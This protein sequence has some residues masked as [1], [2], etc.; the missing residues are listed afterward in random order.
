MERRYQGTAR[1]IWS[2][3]DTTFHLEPILTSTPASTSETRPSSLTPT[4]IFLSDGFVTEGVRRFIPTSSLLL[5]TEP[6]CA[7]AEGEGSRLEENVDDNPYKSIVRFA[8]QDLYVVLGRL[9]Q[10]FRL[11]YG[12]ESGTDNIDMGQV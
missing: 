3:Q 5:D 1:R 4:P 9:V 2:C 6:G 8:E 7:L 10:R 12:A 11:E